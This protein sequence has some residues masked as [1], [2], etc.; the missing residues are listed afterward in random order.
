MRMRM[1]HDMASVGLCV[2]SLIFSSSCSY[3]YI[4]AVMQFFGITTAPLIGFVMDRKGRSGRDWNNK[5]GTYPISA[6]YN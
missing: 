4:F 2:V 3:T 6:W 1:I 5:L